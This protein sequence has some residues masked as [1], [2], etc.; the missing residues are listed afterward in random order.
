MSTY[1]PYTIFPLGDA[2]LTV[3][4]SN[5]IDRENNNKAIQLFHQ[6]KAAGIPYIKSLVPG[7]SSLTIHYD[8]VALHSEAQT[9][10]EKMAVMIENFTEERKPSHSN[11]EERLIKIPVCYEQQFAPDL[12]EVAA[13]KNLSPQEVI[14][15][16]SSKEY[17]VYMLGFVPGFAYMGD[18]DESIAVP[19][20]HQPRLQVDAGSVGIT[21]KQTGIYPFATPG[22]WQIIG[23]T[24]L[25]LFD[26]EEE[27]PVLLH[28]G[29]R[30]KFHSITAD[31]FEDYQGR[32]S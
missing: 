6:L 9:A 22:G 27:Q 18:V 26:R 5:T 23:R 32:N 19:R 11:V 2:A 30:I 3:E 20:R 31:E 15:I 21:G 13:A 7:Y 1:H 24:P 4:F 10:F 29:D 28:P 16:H 25:K 17:R 8:V 14:S 12:F